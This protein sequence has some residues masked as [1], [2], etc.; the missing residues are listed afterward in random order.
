MKKNYKVNGMSC[1]ACSARV[2]RAVNALEGVEACSVNLLSGRMT[3]EGE[4]SEA[5]VIAAVTDAGYG[6]AP[7]DGGAKNEDPFLD[8]DTPVLIKR[9]L[10][11]LGF[12]VLLMYF[13]MGH[14]L[15][16]PMPHFI[17]SSP[18]A[19]GF[20][21]LLLSGIVLVINK[22]FFISGAKSLLRGAPNMDTLVAM[23]SAVSYLYSVYIL[24]LMCVRPE[25]ASELLH[26][27]YFESAAM[28]LALI[29]LG[30]TLEARAKGKTTD[31]LNN[32]DLAYEPFPRIPV[33]EDCV[34]LM[35][36][37]SDILGRANVRVYY[38]YR[39]V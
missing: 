20:V 30:K 27:L 6:A 35:S 21:Q 4:V 2:E 23:G 38:Y 7:E 19:I 1:A 26:N 5:A 9:L 10:F 29:T 28:I 16:I 37:D 13:S 17:E 15:G 31:A 14:M 18:I 3:V 25:G 34:L 8:K 24:V 32:V 11:S 36:A 12:L 33:N 39:S 22:K